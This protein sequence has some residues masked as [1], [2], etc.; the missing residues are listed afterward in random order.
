VPRR[1]RRLLPVGL[2]DPL[3][4]TRDRRGC[5]PLELPHALARDAELT[6]G[7]VECLL[8]ALEAKAKLEEPPFALGQ[9]MER[10]SN[11]VPA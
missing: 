4:L 5:V 1:V 9:R 10:A 2:D 8:V 7:R 3:K 11:Q 6:G